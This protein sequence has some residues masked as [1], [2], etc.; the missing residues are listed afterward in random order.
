MRYHLVEKAL[1][2]SRPNRFI[3]RVMRQGEETVCHVKN[4]GRCR[5]LLIPGVTVYLSKSGNPAR[6][7]QFDLIAVEKTARC[8]ISIPRRPITWPGN[9]WKRGDWG[10]RSLWS[11]RN[12]GSGDSRLDFYYE[13]KDT[14][15][16][17]EVKGVTLE[18][19]GLLMFPDA[20][21]QRGVRHLEELIRCKREGYA[22]WSPFCSPD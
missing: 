19:N 21:T 1:F 4:T 5:E 15:G 6:K 17:L 8:S 20:P 3:A 14:R 16:F 22:A 18:E 12:S 9:G 11:V 7:T 10:R 2:L 13:T